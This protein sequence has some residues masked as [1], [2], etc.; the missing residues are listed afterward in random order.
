MYLMKVHVQ[1]FAQL[2]D[3][4]GVSDA[5]VDV[6]GGGTVSDVLA[7]LYRK[8]PALRAH[9]QAILVGVDVEFVDRSYK[10]KAAEEI[11][12]MPPVQGG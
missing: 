5:V 11:A 3:L 9:D 7:G 4:T 8:F 6:A 12:I 2:R 10:I 1:L